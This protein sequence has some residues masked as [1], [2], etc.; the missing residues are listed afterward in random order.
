M[1]YKRWV[2]PSPIHLNK[3]VT[4]YFKKKMQERIIIQVTKEPTKDEQ[5]HS[6]N[7]KEQQKCSGEHQIQTEHYSNKGNK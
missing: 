6:H 2:T 3:Q 4:G 5:G 7:G 1:S